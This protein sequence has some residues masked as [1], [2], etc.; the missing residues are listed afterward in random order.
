M[1]QEQFLRIPENTRGMNKAGSHQTTHPTD[2][3]KSKQYVF[4][5]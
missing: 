2:I 3:V 5:E 1:T 4:D